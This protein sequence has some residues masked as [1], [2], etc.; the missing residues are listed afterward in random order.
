MQ[1]ITIDND[2][3]EFTNIKLYE[4]EIILSGN[5]WNKTGF[6]GFVMKLPITLNYKVLN[7]E[8]ESNWFEA[9]DIGKIDD[10][11][12]VSVFNFDQNEGLLITINNEKTKII[13]KHHN[14]TFR[15]VNN[16][17]FLKKLL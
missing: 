15:I 13:D 8:L 17:L 16:K 1:D 3:W 11:T 14:K 9:I 4:E 7:I 12:I 6:N 10:T 2:L 5:K